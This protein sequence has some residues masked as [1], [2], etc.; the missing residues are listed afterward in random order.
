MSQTKMEV[1]SKRKAAWDSADDRLN[2]L[3]PLL[4]KKKRTRARLDHLSPE[5]KLERRKEKNRQAAQTAR[6]RKKTTMEIQAARIAQLE[7]E[8]QLLRQQLSGQ[9]AGQSC[10]SPSLD[11]GI[12]D[13]ISTSRTSQSSSSSSCSVADGSEMDYAKSPSQISSPPP[14]LLPP[15][16][17]G[18]LPSPVPTDIDLIDQM[19]MLKEEKLEEYCLPTSDMTNIKQEFASGVSPRSAVPNSSL[20]Q[21]S[22]PSKYLSVVNSLGWTSFQIMIL[23]MISG[24][25]HRYSAKTRC[26]R[27]Q[28]KG[29]TDGI[30]Q[31]ASPHNLVDYIEQTKCDDFH[32]VVES[33][34]ANR[35]DA[36]QQRLVAW[37]FARK[38]LKD[39]Q[40]QLDKVHR[41]CFTL[42]AN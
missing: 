36:I 33:I 18:D 26:C 40:S 5:Q 21:A 24:V 31:V 41:Y 10:A 42:G 3:E 39:N 4:K 1:S 16:S 15:H 6:D 20:P 28:Q 11:S 17:V 7:R 23:L 38:Y 12:S 8:N 2:Q 19:I 29:S 13:V 22:T 35:D 9:A 25:H 14:P 32:R 30:S 37:E 27:K 34:I